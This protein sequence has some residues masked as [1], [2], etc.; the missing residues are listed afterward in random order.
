[1]LFQVG[2]RNRYRHPKS[3]VV[4]R[5]RQR[6][7]QMQRSD[8]AGAVRVES[9]PVLRVGAYRCEQARY[10]RPARCGQD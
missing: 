10:W 7:V 9:A 1:M 5:Y 4:E 8:E 3:E 6:G 2:Y